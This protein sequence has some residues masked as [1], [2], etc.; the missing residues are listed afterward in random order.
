MGLLEIFKASGFDWTV[1]H[2]KEAG[3]TVPHLHFHIVPRRQGDLQSPGDWYSAFQGWVVKNLDS[4]LR[5]RLKIEE[6]EIVAS[7]LRS[8]F[9]KGEWLRLK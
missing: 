2:G 3:Q 5:S 9:E 4:S 6:L 7:H 8:S 1:Q